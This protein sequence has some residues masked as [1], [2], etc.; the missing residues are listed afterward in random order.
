MGVIGNEHQYYFS[1]VTVI[2][3][4]QN[5]NKRQKGY[6]SLVSLNGR[7]HQAHP[8]FFFAVGGDCSVELAPVSW[9]NRYYKNDMTLIWFDAHGDL[10]TQLSSP[11][12]LFHGMPLRILLGGGDPQIL[13]RCLSIVRPAQVIMAGMQELDELEQVLLDQHPIDCVSVEDFEAD[14]DILLETIRKK[15][16]SNVYIRVDLDVL[17]PGRYKNTKHPT[18]KGLDPETLYRLIILLNGRYTIVGCSILKFIPIRD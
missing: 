4:F 12:K 7:D 13:D 2:W 16:F 3:S 15:R 1:A 8:V 6:E 10:N 18:P 5:E 17:D 11:S 14:L 9:L